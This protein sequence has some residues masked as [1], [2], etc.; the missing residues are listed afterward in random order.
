MEENKCFAKGEKAWG[1]AYENTEDV[2]YQFSI[3]AMVGLGCLLVSALMYYMQAKEDMFDQ[4]RPYVILVNLATFVWFVCL[5]Y[6][7][8]KDTGKACSGDYLGPKL[9]ANFNT[10]YLGSLGQ[11]LFIY[12]VA[13]YALYI[14]SKVCSIIITN[15]LEA[16]YE[17]KKAA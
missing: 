17:E 11:W 2:T 16:E 9:P 6:Y 5:Q 3:L 10:I 12:I 14:I 7:R 4:M 1:V 8:F 13:Q 15:S